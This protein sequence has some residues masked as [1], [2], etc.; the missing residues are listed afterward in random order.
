MGRLYDDFALDRL[1]VD[2]SPITAAPFTISAWFRTDDVAIFETVVSLADKDVS[3]R[4]WTI[5]LEG[6][7]PDSRVAFVFRDAGGE[8]KVLTTTDY[9]VNTWHHAFAVEVSSTNHR[10]LLDGAGLGISVVDTTPT[11]IDRISIGRKGDSTPSS[12]FSGRIAEV[13]MWNV[14]LS[15]AQALELAGGVPVLRMRPD[16]LVEYWPCFGVGAPEPDYIGSNNLTVTGAVQADHAPVALPFAWDLGWDGEPP[17][18]APQGRTKGVTK[19]R[20]ATML[21]AAQRDDPDGN[22]TEEYLL[23]RTDEFGRLRVNT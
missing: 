5:E 11:G 3:N 17:L 2:A 23:L 16:A 22:P 15:D 21:A 1:E 20:R 10:I 12:Y 7:D 19:R 13:A 4:Y 6:P 18:A 14:A 9:L 8:Q